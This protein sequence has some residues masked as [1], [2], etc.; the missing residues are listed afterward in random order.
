MRWHVPE[1]MRSALPVGLVYPKLFRA[2]N[3]LADFRL[4]L[5]YFT[6]W[7]KYS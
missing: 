6:F 5:R 3:I 1:L 4:D 7:G 2:P